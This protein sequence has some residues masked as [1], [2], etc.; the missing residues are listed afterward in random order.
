MDVEYKYYMSRYVDNSWEAETSLEDYF[1]GMLY[2]SCSGLSSKGK[3]KN[4][5][6]ESYAE[7]DELRVYLPDVITRENTDIEFSFA[8]K[9]ENRRDIY[10][11]FTDWVSGYK[12]KYWD[13]CR[14]R[15]AEM[16]LQ[17]A[18]ETSDDEIIG[19]EPYITV[20]FKFKNIKGTTEKKV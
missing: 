2:L 15:V 11:K 14:N 10:D 13:T 9:G 16:I 7:T 18:I 20:K 17:E 12:I 4:I 5:Y 6:T 3:P 19:S 1:N 8:F